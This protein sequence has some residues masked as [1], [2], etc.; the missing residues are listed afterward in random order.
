[1]SGIANYDVFVSDNGGANSLWQN[2][3]AAT[4]ATFTGILGHTYT[5]TSIARDQAGN[6]EASHATSDTFTKVIDTTPPTS[7][8]ITLPATTG[9]Y[10]FIVSWSGQDDTGGSGLDSFDILVSDNGGTYILWQNHT[11]TTS[12][13]F[14]GQQGHTYAFYSQA[15]D[16][17]GNLQPAPTA[18]NT[19]IQMI[20]T[21]PPISHV[22]TLPVTTAQYSFP[23]S[24]SGQDDVG[25]S[26]IVDYDVYVS[27]NGG[28]YALWLNHTT[29]T[30]AIYPGLAGHTYAFF[31]EARDNAG[32]VESA[33]ATPE[34]QIQVIDITPPTSQVSP[35]PAVAA[36][37]GLVVSWSGQDDQGGSGIASYD[38]YVSD[39]GGV[40][41]LWQDHTAATSAT[42]YGQFSHTYAFFSRAR[43]QAGNVQAAPAV[44]DTQTITPSAWF[45]TAGND[46]LTLRLDAGGSMVQFFNTAIA[47]TSAP[48]FSL[49]LNTLQPFGIKGLAGNDT[50]TIDFTNGNPVPAGGVTID[51][52]PGIN[53]LKVVGG[54]GNNPISLSSSGVT[55]G[56]QLL[57]TSGVQIVAIAC[58]AGNNSV[59]IAEP[60]GKPF[61]LDPGPGNTTISLTAGTDVFNQN[62]GS[63]DTGTVSLNVAP[64][65]CAVF[66]TPQ[67]LASLTVAAGGQ[68]SLMAGGANLL[69]VGGLNIAPGG[70]VDVADNDLVIT[71]APATEEMSNVRQMLLDG[72]L[73]TRAF[74]TPD[75][76]Y[77]TLAPVDN[78]MLHLTSWSNVPINDGTDFSQ[79]IVKYTCMGDANLDGKVDQ[80]DYL[81][82]IANMGSTNASYFEGDLNGDGM[83]TPD[84]FAIV[85][86]NLG[87][88]ASFAA[89]P[90]ISA[91]SPAPASA[92]M[93]AMAVSA[94]SPM[95]AKPAAKV[96]KPVVNPK[97][98]VVKVTTP[99]AKTAKP[100]VHA[101]TPTPS[102][103][104]SKVVHLVA[105]R[106]A[107]VTPP[108]KGMKLA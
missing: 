63:L 88:G 29:S 67:Q 56:T 102:H 33:P 105:K 90:A 2:H 1:G 45:G 53:T 12:A 8:I 59:S 76:H 39:N 101:K 40:P 100:V 91:A 108:K 18:P 36:S 62:L 103:K 69:R 64:T 104:E 80:S 106:T 5:F 82:I 98:P 61:T 83:V 23:V 10:S 107:P 34:A 48:A 94:A 19:Q 77:A 38:V 7:H 84:D 97:K 43:D 92:T 35:L 58:G 72:R 57:S 78:R 47:G 86:A 27:D 52:G 17:A 99:A 15:R 9:Q 14:A 11:T 4:S 37:N 54:S 70:S 25:G 51:G 44:P 30:T 95:A 85:S 65:A 68:V 89:G 21:T 28:G 41:A 87:A 96:T 81:N 73:F 55:V 22:N 20:D 24:W 71:N 93:S 50:V 42:F 74:Q 26:G 49:P 66:S 32:N 13:T 46:V 3:T 16:N 75:G 60:V 79:V 31:S 6:V